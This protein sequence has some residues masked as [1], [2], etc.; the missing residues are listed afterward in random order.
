MCSQSSRSR[1]GCVH[2]FL[3]ALKVIGLLGSVVST[4]LYVL[5]KRK[6]LVLLCPVTSLS[7]H[8]AVGLGFVVSTSLYV[9]TK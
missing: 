7:A 6:A 2:D 5:T 4:T 1:F 9:L 8:K 3:C